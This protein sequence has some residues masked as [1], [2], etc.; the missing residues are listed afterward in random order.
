MGVVRGDF[1]KVLAVQ[2]GPRAARLSA[3]V[4]DVGAP[5]RLLAPALKAWGDVFGKLASVGTDYTRRKNMAE[6]EMTKER[7]DW[8]TA[9]S[10]LA[11]VE[12]RGAGFKAKMDAGPLSRDDQ[13][14]YEA[15]SRE[16]DAAAQAVKRAQGRVN[17]AEQRWKRTGF[18]GW[19]GTPDWTNDGMG[20][21]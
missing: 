4:P 18:F 21:K 1:E 10:A 16:R 3:D 11:D 12:A 15:W 20:P 14:Q 8:K 7:A 6:A 5:L 19:N 17:M 13:A 2:Q 9:S